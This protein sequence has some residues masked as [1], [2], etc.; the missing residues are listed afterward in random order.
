MA[1]T[2][3]AIISFFNDLLEELGQP[4]LLA[5]PLF[6]QEKNLSSETYMSFKRI[7]DN[8]DDFPFSFELSAQGI[9]FHL[10][11]TDE[12][13]D[14]SYEQMQNN[15]NAV[16]RILK[17][18]FTSR[19]LAVYQGN[20][21]TLLFYDQHDHQVQRFVYWCGLGLPLL[22]RKLYKHYRPVF[23]EPHAG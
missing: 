20:K 19:I 3:T 6:Q 10:D 12:I 5:H 13:P 22:H 23:P 4:A 8:H 7:M 1:P 2:L 17:I 18:I 14:W 15:R 16:R 9:T 11:R 21:T